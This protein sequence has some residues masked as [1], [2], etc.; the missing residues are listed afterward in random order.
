MFLPFPCVFFHSILLQ[1]VNKK[2]SLRTSKT[3]TRIPTKS[4]FP[5][6]FSKPIWSEKDVILTSRHRRVVYH[7]RVFPSIK[8]PRSYHSRVFP[9]IKIL[10]SYH[11]RVFPSIK[12]LC[13]YHSR[14]FPSIKFLSSYHSRVFPSIKI[15]SSYH[16]RVFPSIKILCSYHSRVFPSIKILCS[17][18]SRVFSSILFFYKVLTKRFHYVHRKRGPGFLPNLLSPLC[19]P[20]PFGQKR[21][22]F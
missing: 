8:I 4:S 21:T 17:Y 18:H 3:R 14:V 19:F 13:S 22:S 16:S 2:I 15:L 7:S 9:S 12:I 6:V 1:S 20:S 10:S 5:A 11:S